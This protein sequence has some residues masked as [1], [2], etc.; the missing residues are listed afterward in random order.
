M[1]LEVVFVSFL[2]CEVIPSPFPPPH[3]PLWEDIS[4]HSPHRRS[5]G[6]VLLLLQGGVSPWIVW[7]SSALVIFLLP[8]CSLFSHL[9]QYGCLFYTL[10][11]NPIPCYLF[12]CSNCLSFS[13]WRLFQ[14][15]SVPLWHTP[16]NVGFAHLIPSLL[17]SAARCSRLILQISCPS[18]RTSPFSKEPW[19]FLSE[20]GIRNQE[21]RAG[22][23]GG[24][25]GV[26]SSWVT[27]QT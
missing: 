15:V 27:Q 3:C 9:Y 12:S 5:R 11:H 18:P 17:P 26:I 21:L 6:I 13:H 1:W 14:W 7:N 10:G 20:N 16:I 19:F 22:Y 24:C 25:W 4:V 23:A 8:I 2:H